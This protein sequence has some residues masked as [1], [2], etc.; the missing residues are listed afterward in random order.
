MAGSEDAGRAV[1]GGGLQKPKE[2]GKQ[3][4]PW[5]RR[6]V[7]SPAGP[8]YTSGLQKQK[9]INVVCRFRPLTL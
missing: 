9:I 1:S 5:S 2:T 3:V 6:E 4:L 8:F 7:D